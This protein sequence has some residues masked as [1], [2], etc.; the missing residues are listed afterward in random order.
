MFVLGRFRVER[1]LAIEKVLGL[2]GGTLCQKRKNAYCCKKGLALPG[3]EKR[4][5]V[6]TSESHF[7]YRFPPNAVNPS[8]ESMVMAS[9]KS[10]S[11]NRCRGARTFL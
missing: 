9:R 11:G 10:L 5:W 8:V 1:R 6:L 7:C 4:T 3:A 2:R